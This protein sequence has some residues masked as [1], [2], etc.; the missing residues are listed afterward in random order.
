[1]TVIVSTL[2]SKSS[3][4]VNM[5]LPQS[6]PP[7]IDGTCLSFLSLRLPSACTWP[8]R[9]VLFVSIV[10]NALSALVEEVVSKTLETPAVVS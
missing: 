9:R 3:I 8:I 1:M 2:S 7:S 6:A 10:S 4:S 5:V